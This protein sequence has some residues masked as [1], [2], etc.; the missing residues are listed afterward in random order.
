M[1]ISKQVQS[2]STTGSNLNSKPSSLDR[3]DTKHILMKQYLQQH[4]QGAFSVDNFGTISGS[5]SIVQPSLKPY[6]NNSQAKKP[7]NQASA[8]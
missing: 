2:K 3:G 5:S 1:K 6:Q 8:S 7:K 4:Q